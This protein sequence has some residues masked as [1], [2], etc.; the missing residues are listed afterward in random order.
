[1]GE[2]ETA[3]DRAGA[4]MTNSDKIWRDHFRGCRGRLSSGGQPDWEKA[5]KKAIKAG[6]TEYEIIAG[7]LGYQQAMLETDTDLQFRYMA[8]TFLNKRIFEDYQ[9]EDAARRYLAKPK[10][11]VVR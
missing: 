6:A 11:E 9:N 10:L 7:W 1:M 8:S 5:W 4:K 3:L 2:H